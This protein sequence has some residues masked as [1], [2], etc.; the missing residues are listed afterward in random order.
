LAAANGSP[1]APLV[2]PGF[3]AR[4][5]KRKKG[6]AMYQLLCKLKRNE[7]ALRQLPL[8]T[9]SFLIA[10]LFYKFHSFAL[11]C[12]AFLLT[13]FALDLVAQVILALIRPARGEVAGRGE[14]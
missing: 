13:W 2:R 6:I 1:R 7:L 3:A 4:T 12:G 10:E 5:D 11:E 8:F 14:V 9:T